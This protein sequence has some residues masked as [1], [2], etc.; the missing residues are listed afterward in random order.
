MRHG[1]SENMNPN[2]PIIIGHGQVMEPVST[3][4]QTGSSHAEVAG[5]AARV[6]LFDAGIDGGDVDAVAC[7]RTF[8]DSSPAYACP[9][10][11]PDKFPRAVADRMGASPNRAIYDVIGGQSPQTLIAEFTQELMAGRAQCVVIAGGEALAN[12]RAAQRAGESLDW[13]ERHDDDWEDRGLFSG[14][15]IVSQTELAHGLLDAMSY[16]GFIETA[17]RIAARRSVS[18]HRKYMAE[19]IAPFSGVAAKNPFAMFD[20]I[21]TPDDIAQPNAMN[22]PLTSPFLKDMVAKDRVN[23]GAAI[24]MTTVATAERLGVARDKWVF[25]RGHAQAQEALMLDRTVLSHSLAM[26]L[27]FDGALKAAGI[28]AD[29]IDHADIYSCFPCVVDQ[30]REALDRKDKPLTLTGGLPFFGGPGNNYTLHGICEVMRACRAAPGSLG[31]AHGNGGWMSKQAVGIYSTEYVASDIFADEAALA[32]KI[33]IQAAPG[34][35]KKPDGTARLESYIVQHKRGEPIGATVI[36]AVE[37]GERFYAKLEEAS[38][39][40]LNQLAQGKLDNAQLDVTPGMPA[41][42]ARL[43]GR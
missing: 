32:A 37:S 41:N 34:Q 13:S 43:I 33:A 19:L 9:F 35:A 29:D 21:Y 7:V 20:E 5:R 18:D 10:G 25:L 30:A 23:Q 12:M 39:E 36:G 14:P 24:V 6:A 4:L 16:Y 31:L 38:A 22:R 40:T 26:D 15:P 42:K 27:V 3:D 17:R 1:K 2:T 11:G 28:L 8:S